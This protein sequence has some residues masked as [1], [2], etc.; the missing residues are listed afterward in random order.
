MELHR[1]RGGTRE[2]LE[3]NQYTIGVGISIGNKWFT[4]EHI[5]GLIQWA[6]PYTREKV[7]VY[8]ADTIHAINLETRGHISA[9]RALSIAQRKGR[10]IL[11]DVRIH[12]EKDL[13][14]DQQSR[15]IYATWD[16]VT[17]DTYQKK[18]ALCY[19]FY[20]SRPDFKSAIESIVC[21]WIS[22]EDRVFT[23]AEVDQFCSYILE[24]LPEITARVPIKGVVCDAY[25]YPTDGQLTQLVEKLQLGEIFPE[26][27]AKILDT[28]PRVFLEVR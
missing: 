18:V 27:Q 8:A 14:P 11:H 5:V 10:E 22:K 23:E 21:S 4:A 19:D 26:L 24:E 12:V 28:E 1:I 2:E 20:R 13:S 16:D 9:R 3:A 17:T 15:V 6:L 25:T 7:I